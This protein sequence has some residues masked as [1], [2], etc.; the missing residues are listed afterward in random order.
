MSSGQD[1]CALRAI[2]LSEGSISCICAR[3]RKDRGRYGQS[4]ALGFVPSSVSEEPGRSELAPSYLWFSHPSAHLDST[5][6]PARHRIERLG[7]LKSC[8]DQTTA[9]LSP[10][11]Y[12]ACSMTPVEAQLHLMAHQCSGK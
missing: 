9:K 4:C 3:C 5:G 8:R 7:P 6:R 12:E 11:I 10:G 1:L 2:K